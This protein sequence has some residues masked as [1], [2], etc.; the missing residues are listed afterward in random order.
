MYAFREYI[1]AK[2]NDCAN[3]LAPHVHE[4]TF[5]HVGLIN[6]PASY[7]GAYRTSVSSDLMHVADLCFLMRKIFYFS[8]LIKVH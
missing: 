5:M 6:G 2:G 3:A 7:G 1:H 8:V 4:W